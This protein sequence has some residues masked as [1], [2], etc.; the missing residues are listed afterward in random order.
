MLPVPLDIVNHIYSFADNFIPVCKENNQAI[1]KTRPS[2]ILLNDMI[3][4]L[5]LKRSVS[6]TKYLVKLKRLSNEKL[7]REYNIE[8][9]V[10]LE[11]PMKNISNRCTARSTC[12]RCTKLQM[13]PYTMCDSHVKSAKYFWLAKPIVFGEGKKTDISI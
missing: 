3:D 6:A 10:K 7:K 4:S 1:S 2:L 11:M 8:R 5:R 13:I 9:M 12:G